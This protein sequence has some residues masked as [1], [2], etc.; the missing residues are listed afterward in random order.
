MPFLSYTQVPMR[1]LFDDV[2]SEFL[3][4]VPRKSVQAKEHR[5]QSMAKVAAGTNAGAGTK[6][7]ALKTESALDPRR[8]QNL[9]IMLSKF[10]KRTADD[11]ATKVN[12]FDVDGLGQAALLTLSQNIP[13]H[14]EYLLVEKF[15]K[16][17]ATKLEAKAIEGACTRVLNC[18]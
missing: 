17:L 1:I 13:E 15:T 4:T 16:D 7:K 6:N 11:I 5:R 10:G 14:S 12:A 8:N 18:A 9:S 3:K 2:E